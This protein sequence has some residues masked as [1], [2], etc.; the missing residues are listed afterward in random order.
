MF[1]LKLWV[2]SVEDGE[3]THI[4]PVVGRSR[5]KSRYLRISL[6]LPGN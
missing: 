2:T 4:Y 1:S 3:E 6:A 5:L